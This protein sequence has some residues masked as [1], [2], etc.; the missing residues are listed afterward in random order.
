MR[1]GCINATSP[2]DSSAVL[3]ASFL[4]AF[5]A[6]EIDKGATAEAELDRCTAAGMRFYAP[7]VAFAES[8]YVLCQKRLSGELTPPEYE[9]AL[10]RF[11]EITTGIS[12]PPSDDATLVPRSI[13][14]GEGYGCSRTNDL[15]Y[16]ALAEELT[17]AGPTEIITF[18]AGMK[19]QANAKAPTVA[20][21]LLTVATP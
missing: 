3:D 5:A 14:I 1:E 15:F 2:L 18:D 19:K 16:I 7:G 9:I 6:N 11:V 10:E 12:P 4:V 17:A 13:E 21:R 20:V 8:L